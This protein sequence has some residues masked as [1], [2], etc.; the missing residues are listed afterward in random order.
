MKCSFYVNSKQND[1]VTL[2]I[3]LIY[4]TISEATYWMYGKFSAAAFSALLQDW[5]EH[6]GSKS[7][8][9]IVKLRRS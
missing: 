3:S 2:W 4:D 7:S 6:P 9:T 1:R 8:L 5:F